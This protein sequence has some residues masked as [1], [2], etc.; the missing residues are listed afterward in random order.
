[1]NHLIAKYKQLLDLQDSRFALIEHEDAMVAVV[2]K[3]TVASGKEYVLKICSRQGDYLRESYFLKSFEGKIPVPRIIQLVEPK[4]DIHGAILMEC[5]P[6]NLLN[7]ADINEKFAYEIG[8]ILAKIHATKTEGYGDL[9]QPNELSLDPCI[10]FTLKFEEGLDECKDHLP[11]GL[12]DQC[13]LAFDRQINLLSKAD[14]PCIV[15]RDFRPG[16]VIVFN[17][18]IQGVIDWSSGRGGFAEEDFCP[19]EQDE[20]SQNHSNKKA[21]LTG[22]ASIRPIPNYPEL[23]PFLRLSKAIGVIGFTVKRGTWNSTHS[24]L[25]QWNRQHL[26]ELL[27]GF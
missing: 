6:G 18:Q 16:N 5:L 15:H 24:R 2:Y 26:E 19:I 1:M 9:T 12:I 21:L 20:W 8:C 3:V 17:N 22:Y 13:R 11:G 10:P 27:K 4:A 14:G 7:V 23:M 25:Y